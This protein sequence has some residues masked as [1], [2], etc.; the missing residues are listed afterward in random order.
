MNENNL[1]EIEE[2]TAKYEDVCEELKQVKNFD[3]WSYVKGNS[4]N[5][6]YDIF[7]KY[8]ITDDT[9]MVDDWYNVYKENIEEVKI[10]YPDFD[11]EDVADF[12][13]Y[14]DSEFNEIKQELI[15][16]IEKEIED[17]EEELEYKIENFKDYLY[18]LK[19]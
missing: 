5:S 12:C 4:N 7:E 19:K 9:P 3:G 10:D 17:I 11:G 2:L 13:Y 1:C 18:N 16:K 14:C 15:E 8:G 6:L